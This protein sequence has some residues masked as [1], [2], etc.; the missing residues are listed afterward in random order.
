MAGVYTSTYILEQE[1]WN[2]LFLP[3]ASALIPKPPVSPVH[4]P[5]IFAP[6]ATCPCGRESLFPLSIYRAMQIGRVPRR[7]HRFAP[8]CM[9]TN[10]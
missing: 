7:G 10:E 3:V 6:V 8:R 1:M 4:N 5:E 9:Q 2:V